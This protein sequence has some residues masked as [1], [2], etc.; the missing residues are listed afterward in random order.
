M[1]RNLIAYSGFLTMAAIATSR[2]LGCL[3]H[4]ANMDSAARIISKPLVSTLACLAIWIIAFVILSPIT[5]SLTI[6]PYYFGT[7][8]YDARHGK[9]EV[10]NCQPSEGFFPGGFIFSVVF[11]VPFLLILVSHVI[12]SFI[13]ELERRRKKE[14]LQNQSQVPFGQIQLTLLALSAAYVAFAL[15]VLVIENVQLE[16]EA[17]MVALCAYSWYWWMYVINFILYVTTLSDFRKMY[18]Q[19]FEDLFLTKTLISSHQLSSVT[20]D[21]ISDP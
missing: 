1:V 18:K 5:F 21:D 6:G 10:I 14:I 13:L 8:G 9:C 2:S 15:P 20:S 3:L 7:F 16:E 11:F 4:R 12:I 19:L 17:E